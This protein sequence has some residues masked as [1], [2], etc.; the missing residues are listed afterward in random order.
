MSC[1][2]RQFTAKVDV[3]RVSRTE[4][5]DVAGFQADVRITCDDCKTPFV[6]LG[7]GRVGLSFEQPMTNI[8]GTELR[9]PIA[10]DPDWTNGDPLSGYQLRAG[11][12][13]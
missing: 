2:H 1:E 13:A 10:P 5:G 4:G 6:F 7:V 9:I 11:A 8:E 12:N 3:N